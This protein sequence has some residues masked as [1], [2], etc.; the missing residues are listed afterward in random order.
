[1]ATLESLK[2]D[3]ILDD[4]KFNKQ[5]QG[6][7]ASATQLNTQ[8]SSLLTIQKSS[9]VITDKDVESNKNRNK[10]LKQNVDLR[11]DERKKVEQVNLA[12]QKR[13]QLDAVVVNDAAIR[14]REK[15]AREVQKTASAQERLNRAI[16]HQ[17][18]ADMV[19][20][21]EREARAVL[22]TAMAQE[23]LN[24]LQK[25][26]QESLVQTNKLW[27]GI[28]TLT[29]G[30]FSILGAKTLVTSLVQVS[31]EFEK[32]RVSLEA[33]LGDLRGAD[34]LFEKIRQ[35]AVM[36]PF[37]FKELAS[38]TKQLAAFSVPMEDLYDTTKMLADVSA[39]LGVGMDRIILAYGQIRSA[40]FLRGQEVRQLTEAG[41]PILQELSKM[42][43]EIE[44]KYV[45]VGEVFDKISSRQVTFEMVNQIFKDMTSEGGKFYQMQEVLAETLSGK[46]SNLK[47]AYQ[48][49]FYEIGQGNSG[50]LNGAVDT[51]RN[52][53][54][55]Y[56]AIGKALK[57]LIVVYGTYRAAAIAASVIEKVALLQARGV[58]IAQIATAYARLTK[59][60]IAASNAQKV[61]NAVAA[62]NPYVAMATAIT[63]ATVATIHLARAGKALATQQ[64]V[65]SKFADEAQ[66]SIDAEA[67]KLQHLKRVLENASSDTEEY[68]KARKELLTTYDQYLSDLDRENILLGNQVGIYDEILTRIRAVAGEKALAEANDAILEKFTKDTNLIMDRYESFLEEF[69]KD[70]NSVNEE[71]AI[72]I[73]KY[74]RNEFSD[75]SMFSDAAKELYDN[76]NKWMAEKDEKLKKRAA[77][78]NIFASG[79]FYQS[80][81]AWHNQWM[82]VSKATEDEMK[83][84]SKRIGLLFG[85]KATPAPSEL[86]PWQNT[87]KKIIDDA[88][89]KGITMNLDFTN[90][91]LGS[92]IDEVSSKIKDL[93]EEVNRYRGIDDDIADSL[94]KQLDIWKEIDRLALNGKASVGTTPL[95]TN[96]DKIK[97][98]KEQI[99]LYQKV[100]DVYEEMSS[101]LGEDR[102]KSAMKDIYG[103][104]LGGILDE[105]W[106]TK[107][108]ELI[109]Q[110]SLLGEEGQKAADALKLQLADAMTKNLVTAAN[111][112]A[113]A[114]ERY[115]KLMDQLKNGIF[116]SGDESTKG[117][118]NV[119]N[120]YIEG[121]RKIEQERKTLGEDVKSLQESGIS[122]VEVDAY[123]LAKTAEID[124][125]AANLLTETRLDLEK[126]I[127]GWT[128]DALEKKG[129][130]LG[131]MSRMS[132]RQLKDLKQAI[133]ELNASELNPE[134][135]ERLAQAGFTLE[136]VINAMSGESDVLNSQVDRW[137]DDTKYKNVIASLKAIKSLMSDVSEYA[138]ATGNNTL[139]QGAKLIGEGLEG[140]MNVMDRLKEGD[141]V[142]AVIAGVSSL[143]SMVLNAATEAAK[144]KE[145]MRQ[146]K[147]EVMKLNA[148]LALS[149]GVETYFG[150]DTIRS[151]KNAT[152][153]INKYYEALKEMTDY[154]PQQTYATN[155]SKG[156]QEEL[157]KRQKNLIQPIDRIKKAAEE[158][159]ASLYNEDGS[160]NLDTLNLIKDTY[161]KLDKSAKNWL[162]DAIAETEIYQKALEQLESAIKEVW[163]GVASDITDSMINAYLEMGDA[164]Y[165]LASNMDDIFSNL[166]KSIAKDMIQSFVISDVIGKYQD[167]VTALYKQM[168]KG[169]IGTD[170]LAR[171]FAEIADSVTSE[172]SVAADFTQRLMT[173]MEQY[174]VN[175]M[176]SSNSDL[177][178]G[179]KSIT[180]NTADLLAAYVNGIR[181]DVAG[182]RKDIQGIASDVKV[183]LG[184]VPTH[185][186]LED[187]LTRIEAHTADNAMNTA[188]I[189]NRL[190]SII[191]DGATSFVRVQ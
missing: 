162:D 135:I 172:V 46:I 66:D 77:S 57:S 88:Q 89:K 187:Y 171:Q 85:A 191:G 60:I 7:I 167:D 24:Q 150:D 131:D 108:V 151:I 51:A 105:D 21:R 68:N 34:A 2:F 82:A 152:E 129:F 17:A 153:A 18:H 22:K 180:E 92:V 110:L 58:A 3:L 75:P 147:I 90:M 25:R 79:G 164:A 64:D 107:I 104:M 190:E 130:N 139:A 14:S 149:A 179:I 55:N 173:A 137:L 132:V 11:E 1:M 188:S 56:E 100:K 96:A 115:N 20:N 121:Q 37:N 76:L 155:I 146:A 185:M 113:Q 73:G 117:I 189:L 133:A 49:M 44:G 42:L 123:A 143:V 175:F 30:Y 126:A 120:D 72:E 168:A 183:L 166:A 111:K 101:A 5:V 170:E 54:E 84:A 118:E 127:K 9:A 53:I 50:I 158:L 134:L 103:D 144:F 156:V 80:L 8:L 62:V 23:R 141:T 13:A 74:L 140:V 65:V 16:G 97:S 67:I 109:T 26:G 12:L 98:L 29:A 102:A 184:L 78:G 116:F 181:A 69:K 28:K 163:N 48:N 124:R 52:L 178:S 15:E 94:Q 70:N 71:A 119:I 32:Q 114:L 41:V 91:G 31:A 36:S 10:I 4:E 148:E 81:D 45:S 40:S 47:D 186:S 154:Q 19:V 63:A 106:N 35:L 39:G 93:T 174:G 145:Q 59:Q 125:E 61:L 177:A 138:E 182:Q 33:I 6:A 157:A 122:E 176:N 161:T 128:S 159:G 83:A 38:Y 165:D 27:E 136:D 87:I 99:S 95:D 169:E 43:T 86:K 160:F 112:S 142:G